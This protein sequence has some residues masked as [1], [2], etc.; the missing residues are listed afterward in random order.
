MS[1]HPPHYGNGMS[2]HRPDSIT[3][4]LYV[5]TPVFNPQRYRMRWKHYKNFEKH[6]LDS[7]AHLVS[8]EATFG[9]RSNVVVN[10]ISEKHTIINVTTNH[11]IWIKENLI[12]LAISRL[13]E[14]WKYVAWVDA[15]IMFMRPDWVGETIHQLQHYDVLQMFSMS[16][17]VDSEFVPFS[18]ST[19][20]C[21]DYIH[22]VP[23]NDCYSGK[24]RKPNHWHTG[25]AWAA[26]RKAITDLGGL[27]DHAILGSADNHMARCLIGQW[28]KSCN[29]GVQ[30]EYKDLLKVWQDRAEKY[31]KRNIGYVKGGIVHYFHGAKVNRRYKDR[32][33][34]LVNNQFKP[35]LDLKRDWNGIYQLT[36]RSF[37]LK[38]DI[39]EYFRQRNEDDINMR[40]V[41]GFF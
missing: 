5:I 20:F 14:D 18:M 24:W 31:V 32:W 12:N 13:P 9:Q 22:G 23:E 21:H 3:D 27:I 11:E 25:Y 8:V 29:G 33:Q 28:E 19:S 17:D 7:G 16:M 4:P 38:R 15:D 1:H 41:K 36:D 26:T 40:G 2:F 35:S 37:Q 30:Q 10:Q 34:I 39:Q 6:V